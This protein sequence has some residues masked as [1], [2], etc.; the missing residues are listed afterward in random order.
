M[1]AGSAKPYW[2]SRF[3]SRFCGDESGSVAII[4]GLTLTGIIMFVACAIDIGRANMARTRLTTAVDATTLY[5]AKELRTKGLDIAAIRPI[6][7]D[8]FNNNVKSAAKLIT[9]TGFD[10]ALAGNGTGVTIDVK[11]EIMTTFARIAGINKINLPQSATAVFNEQDQ[12]VEVA[13]QLDVTGS[14]NDRIN[15]ARKIDSLKIASSNL[16]DI[17]L[18]ASGN[19]NA[20]FRVGI[21]PFSAGVNAGSYAQAVSGSAAPGGCVFERRST[22]N[23]ASDATPTGPDSLKTIKDLGPSANAISPACPTNASVTALTNDRSKLQPTINALAPGGWTSGHLGTTWAWGLVSPNWSAVW[24]ANSKPA[25][26]GDNSTRKIAILMTDGIYN[27]V[28]GTNDGTEFGGSFGVES[29]ARA[30]ALCNAMKDKGITIYTVGFIAS[31]D[32][33]A[34][35]DTLKACANDDSHFYHAEDGNQLDAAFRDIAQ[36]ISALRLSK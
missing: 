5:A 9:V 25:P 16:L 34:A 23:D 32:N 7:R 35:A 8:F 10:V 29:R 6:A 11:A 1:L 19:G 18:P 12:N 36:K 13:L 28:G 22:F 14:M 20:K 2:M 3:T 4:F 17:L 24:P 31:G 26:Y 21:A 33:A 27:T 15:G 30:V